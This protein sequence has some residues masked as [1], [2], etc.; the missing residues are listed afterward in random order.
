MTSLSA[1]ALRLATLLGVW[2]LL[3]GVAYAVSAVYVGYILGLGLPGWTSLVII[4]VL[5]SSVVLICR[6]LVSE[7]VARIF[8]EVKGWPLYLLRRDP[9]EPAP[10]GGGPPRP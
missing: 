5:V 3:C 8:D 4:N 2:A 10:G 1:A 7:Y 6:G 9:R